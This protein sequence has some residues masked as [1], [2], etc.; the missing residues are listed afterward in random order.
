MIVDTFAPVQS[1]GE[2]GE[3]LT[4]EI[5]GENFV[6]R[7]DYNQ[8]IFLYSLSV[9]D[10]SEKVLFSALDL[11]PTTREMMGLNESKNLSWSGFFYE[12]LIFFDNKNNNDSV[13]E[14]FVRG[15]RFELLGLDR[16]GFD[17]LA[18]SS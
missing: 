16:D 11:T 5:N 15:G 13:V 9:T 18:L 7:F 3:N 10:T 6:F 17:L 8:D 4:V 1:I 2:Q 14:G 12:F